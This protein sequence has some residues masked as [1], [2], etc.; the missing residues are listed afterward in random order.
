MS[1]GIRFPTSAPC[2]AYDV[3]MECQIV[4]KLH[5]LVFNRVDGVTAVQS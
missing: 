2:D 1:Y 4:K 3:K 5:L